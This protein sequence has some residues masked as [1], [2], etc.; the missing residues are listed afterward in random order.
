MAVFCEWFVC[1]LQPLHIGD[2]VRGWFE[3]ESIQFDNGIMFLSIYLVENKY[4]NRRSI[5]VQKTQQIFSIFFFLWTGK[6][7][8]HMIKTKNNHS[9]RLFACLLVC[10]FV[11]LFV[12]RSFVRSFFR[13]FVRSFVKFVFVRSLF[14]HIGFY[15]LDLESEIRQWW[16]FSIYQTD[17]TQT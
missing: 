5:F 8:W 14:R 13:S 17:L 6:Q 15:D 7:N 16:Q 1:T 2:V 3:C 12:F 10:L 9:V 4:N 11:C